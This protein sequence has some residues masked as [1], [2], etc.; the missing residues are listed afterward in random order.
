MFY[1]GNVGINDVV[2]GGI[3]SN[4]QF[5]IVHVYSSTKEYYTVQK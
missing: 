4:S 1:N 2:R 5:L 3:N